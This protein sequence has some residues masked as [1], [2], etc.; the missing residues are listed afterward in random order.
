MEPFFPFLLL[1]LQ[2][3]IRPMRHSRL[4]CMTHGITTR[5]PFHPQVATRTE[6]PPPMLPKPEAN[7]CSIG[8]ADDSMRPWIR[9]P[10]RRQLWLT[11]MQPA[12]LV[13]ASAKRDHAMSF[14]TC[15]LPAHTQIHGGDLDLARTTELA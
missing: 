9:T 12:R 1:P 13:I 4:A 2:A 11:V 10:M 3:G 7:P 15:V 6:I 5:P 8:M 14:I